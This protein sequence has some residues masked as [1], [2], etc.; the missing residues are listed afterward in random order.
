MS[1]P[2]APLVTWQP[3]GDAMRISASKQILLFNSIEGNVRLAYVEI[4]ETDDRGDLR[5]CYTERMISW[6][7]YTHYSYA[8]L[9]LETT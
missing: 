9:P 1:D 8:C 4:S 7:D 5:D 2:I 6:S 3:I